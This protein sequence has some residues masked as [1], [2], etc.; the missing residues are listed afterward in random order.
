MLYEFE[1]FC[2]DTARRE[3][4]RANA[5]LQV[6]PKAFD[7]IEF[8]IRN[9]D[10]VVSK[11]ELL[12]AVWKGRIV[13]E[14]ALT[15][16]INAA[17]TALGDSG[18]AQRLLRTSPRK[19][20]RF[21]GAV[22]EG[23]TN[24]QPADLAEPADK[25]S[26]S[27]PLI[28]TSDETRATTVRDGI[29]IAVLPF[30][31]LSD[32]REQEYFA[33]GM[34]DELIGTLSRFKSFFV[35]ARSS[36]FTYK[37]RA[38][39]AKQVGREL[40]VRYV[41]EGSVRK[42]Q[43]QVRI[44]AN[45]VDTE[46]GTQLWADRFDGALEDIFDLQDRVSLNVVG[47]MAPKLV[48]AEIDRAKRK[49]TGSLD[50]Y[51]NYL[52]GLEKAVG[53]SHLD[54]DA[55]LKLFYRAIELDPQFAA[56]YGM[57]AWCYVFSHI[58]GWT[59]DYVGDAPEIERLARTAAHFGTNDAAALAYAGIALARLV[60]DLEGGIALTD[61]ALALNPNL[62]A[63][64][65]FSG[66]ARTFVGETDT[67]ISHLQ[68]AMQLSPLDPLI[69]LSQMCMSLALF[70]AGRYEEGASWAVRALQVKPNFQAI[71]RL[72]IVNSALSGRL[73]DAKRSMKV[74]ISL[75]PAMRLSNLKERIGPFRQED[76]VRYC[77]ALRLAGLPE[78]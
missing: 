68:R 60:G 40:G 44:A 17:R 16:C 29:S 36:S 22:R 1:D 25:R 49:P 13:S 70:V 38:I 5:L 59:S 64:W 39:E 35:I 24:S 15:T 6:E 53:T 67:A 77:D 45:L 43:A 48:Q 74:A 33:D 10:R 71:M 19:G 30:A 9:R 50:A 20:I 34:V 75:D 57:A 47:A 69:F 37:G 46:T 12:S 65:T 73:D 52:R 78:S 61:R 7:V 63:A 58:N 3:L 32:D 14:S 2:L 56:A 55:A 62:A 28:A 27:V 4:R 66:W 23:S 18:E 8:L 72:L 76:I 42:A 31:N 26:S 51:D 11:D 41:V 54:N 21:V